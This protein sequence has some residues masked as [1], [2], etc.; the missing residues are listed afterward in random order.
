MV[1]PFP[2]CGIVI[3]SSCSLFTWQALSPAR[4]S[5]SAP[6]SGEKAFG[7]QSTY[8]GRPLQTLRHH[9]LH[10]RHSTIPASRGSLRTSSTTS[11]PNLRPTTSLK[12][13]P[14]GP[15]SVLGGR[16]DFRPP[17]RPRQ[18]RSHRRLLPNTLE[19]PS[20]AILGAWIESPS[21]R[22]TRSPLLILGRHALATP[23]DEYA[24]PS[25]AHR[26]RATRAPSQ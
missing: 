14:L 9:A 16:K 23:V 11:P 2:R 5:D 7:R 6:P 26:C 4:M 10:R 21:P 20:S 15:S 25:L 19:R 18:E 8:F 13:T 22:S 1:S 24:V 17:I 12:K 3:R